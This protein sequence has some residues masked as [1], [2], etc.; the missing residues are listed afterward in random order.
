MGTIKSAFE[1][2]MARTEDVAGDKEGL[3]IKA[4]EEEG[5]KIAS[6]FLLDHRDPKRFEEEFKAAKTGGD[7]RAREARLA[8]AR[9]VFKNNL[10][11]PLYPNWPETLETLRLGYQVMASHPKEVNAFFK[12]A[13]A[14][15]QQYWQSRE[16][17]GDAIRAQLQETA[18]SRSEQLTAQSGFKVEL[19]PEELPEY[20]RAF[21]EHEGRLTARF[22][23]AL[24]EVKTGLDRFFK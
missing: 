13:A 18:R 5:K 6:S 4:W 10:C 17:L 19:D 3:K 22:R 21:R 7:S 20:A 9:E 16:Q 12:E 14:F 24:E 2:A 8:G 1:I 15:F 11:L 23:T